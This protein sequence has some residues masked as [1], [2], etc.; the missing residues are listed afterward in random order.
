MSKFQKLVEKTKASPDDVLR[1]LLRFYL[2]K[3]GKTGEG[4]D[5]NVK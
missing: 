2:E 3:I 1:C 5:V 4:G